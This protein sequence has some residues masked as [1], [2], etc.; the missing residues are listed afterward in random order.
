MVPCNFRR[1]QRS[2]TLETFDK[3]EVEN[4]AFFSSPLRKKSKYPS[5]RS[6]VAV[7]DGLPKT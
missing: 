4:Q 6:G 1:L 7:T 5:I 2:R 3:D